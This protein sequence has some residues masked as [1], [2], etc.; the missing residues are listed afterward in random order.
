M[1]SIENATLRTQSWELFR[2][3]TKLA[4]IGFH[5][6]SRKQSISP[7][8]SLGENGSRKRQGIKMHMRTMQALDGWTG[9]I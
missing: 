6:I 9:G 8:I 4:V 3:W 7:L 5:T 2:G 1:I